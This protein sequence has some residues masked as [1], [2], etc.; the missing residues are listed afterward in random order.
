MFRGSGDEPTERY[1]KTCAPS[2]S[3]E[4]DG[5]IV[6]LTTADFGDVEI[7]MARGRA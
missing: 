1:L 7:R 2:A 5:Q 6:E 3:S 4:A